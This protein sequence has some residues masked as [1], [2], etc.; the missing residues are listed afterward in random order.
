MNLFPFEFSLVLPSA[1]HVEMSE[2]QTKRVP[3]MN[4][5]EYLVQWKCD[6][7]VH[8]I[9]P[10]SQFSFALWTTQSW[11][12]D[13]NFKPCLVFFHTLKPA[14]NIYVT[15]TTTSRCLLPCTADPVLG[16]NILLH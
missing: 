4:T 6:L 15:R 3:F 11:M 16:L 5:D 1:L 12:L 2:L 14:N 10:Q 9:G 13:E 8:L 7:N